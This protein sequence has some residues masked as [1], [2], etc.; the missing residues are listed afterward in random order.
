MMKFMKRAVKADDGE[1]K[2]LSHISA[3][4]RK[5]LFSGVALI[6][7][8]SFFAITKKGLFLSTGNLINIAQQ[9]VTYAI[10]GYGLTFCL[11]SGGTDLSAGASMALSGIIVLTLL[12]MGIPWPIAFIASLIFGIL[13]G[14]LNGFSIEVLGVVPFIATLGTQWV[15]RGLANVIVDGKPIYTNVIASQ[16]TQDIFYLFGAG[17]IGGTGLPYSVIIALVYGIILYFVLA[18]TRIGREIYAC[19]SNLEAAKL[20]GI[21]TVRTRMFAYC[22]SGFSAAICGILVTSRISS[23]QPMAGQGYELEAI[24]ASVLGG[25]SNSGGEGTII[26]TIIGALMMGVLRNGLNLSGVNSFIQQVII[27]FIL[28]GAVALEVYRHKKQS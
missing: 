1:V 14:I 8:F 3:S 7:L 26:N 24:A 16:S 6:L 17:K 28:V 20:S 19:G 10:I 5:A 22:V 25:V 9:V 11:V 4:G 23:A 13:M 12:S 21:N 2:V 18:K 15:F 27:G